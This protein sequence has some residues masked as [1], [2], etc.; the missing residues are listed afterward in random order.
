MQLTLEQYESIQ[1]YLEG[2][3]TPQEQTEFLNELNQNSFLKESFEFEKEL[4]QNLSSI[5]D[6]KNLWEKENSYF[7][8]DTAFEEAAS[9]RGLI[10]RSANEWKDE[11]K[12]TSMRGGGHKAAGIHDKTQGRKIRIINMQPWIISAAAACTIFAVVSLKWFMPGS[13]GPPP[14]V[15]TIDT[16][17]IRKDTNTSSVI[18]IPPD[19]IKNIKS[20]TPKINF[21]ALFRKYHAKD[22]SS[23]AMPDVLAMVP[24][25]Y[26]NGDYSFQ[27]INLDNQPHVRGSAKDI[28]SPQNILQLGHYY[29]GLSFIETNNNKQAIENLQWVVDNAQDQQ[30]KIKAQWYLAL[31]YMKESNTKKVIPLLNSLSSNSKAIPY[32]R[33][34]GEILEGIKK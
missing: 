19:S 9:I 26:K 13:S 14:I 28:N 17:I 11:N 23:P 18:T 12:K 1:N 25:N 5:L 24:G 27:Q 8:E 34:A 21:A 7:E 10:E 3:M 15:Q 22:L 32:N 4:R 29:K 2:L 30:L 33:Q 6:K 20:P 31:V 16:T